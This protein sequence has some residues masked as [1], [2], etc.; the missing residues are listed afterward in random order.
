MSKKNNIAGT[1]NKKQ[2][3]NDSSTYYLLVI[4]LVT[5]IAFSEILKNDFVNFDD[6]QYVTENP[7][8]QDLNAANFKLF[9]TQQFVGNYQPLT[10]LFYAIQF[11][12][13]GAT[14]GS[15][16]FVSLLFHI[17]NALLLFKIV[18]HL[19]KSDRTAFIVAILFGIHPLHVESVAWIASQKDV[20]Y[21]LFFL[22]S[23]WYYLHYRA[24][25]ISKYLIFSALFFI[26][27][28]LCKAQAVVLPVVLLLLDYLLE[29]KIMLTH[30]KNKL[31]FFLL[32][33]V[34][35]LIAVKAQGQAGA[36]QDF[37]Y[38]RFHERVLFA[39]YAFANYLYQTILPVKLSVFYPYPETNGDIN[40]SMVYLSGILVL[41]VLFLVWY[42]R[43]EK[44]IVFGFLFF[45]ITIALLL[46]LIPVGDAIHA[47]RYSYLSLIGL[48][49]II[50]CYLNRY[51]EKNGNIKYVAMAVGVL[52]LAKTYSQTAVWNNNLALYT[53]AINIEPAAI[54]L[55]NRGAEYYKQGMFTEALADF[56]E[57]VN[58]KPN[59]PNIFTNRAL[60]YQQLGKHTEAIADFSSSIKIYPTNFTLYASRA[61]SYKALKETLKAIDDYSQIIKINAG[62]V[63]A[64]Y[65]RAELYGQQNK[66]NEALAD[67]TESIKLKPNFFEAYN[68]RA[69]VYSMM[70]NLNMAIADYSKAIEI[71]PKFFN[72]YVN[73]G[74]LYKNAGAFKEALADI[75]FAKA[76]GYPIDEKFL[77]EIVQLAAGQ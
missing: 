25:R 35:G 18:E 12:F 40:N 21:T 70:G 77:N 28:I 44:M 2:Q 22:L 5:F 31:L 24:N 46:Q 17:F 34:F 68:N 29:E 55:S 50:G 42:F 37:T 52:L 76:N 75:N 47:D 73:R 72:A 38:F 10:M 20:F 57:V 43:K 14:A 49:V 7:I 11:K 26:C 53:N 23:I 65:A 48:F 41:V 16:H 39:S 9:F 67:L 60:T 45:C 32:A 13:F 74:I 69:I 62:V 1:K 58:S 66:L 3:K 63:D 27:S 71:N 59:F 36:M 56:T 15:F 51:I 30:L 54:T 6:P 8:V 64:W 61:I 33:F 19:F 4:I